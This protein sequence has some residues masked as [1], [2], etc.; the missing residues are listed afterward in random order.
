MSAAASTVSTAPSSP[1]QYPMF[2]DLH[3]ASGATTP[4]RRLSLGDLPPSPLPSGKHRIA[5]IGSGS[6][7]TALA[8]IAAENAA[9]HADMFEPTVNMWVREK[10][11]NGKKL[12]EVINKTHTNQRYLPD[13]SLPANL[14]AVPRLPDVVRNATLIVFVTPHQFLPTVISDLKR[15]G[16]IH[17]QARAVSA[18]KGVEVEGSEIK[19][20][21]SVIERDLSIP[22]SAL[23]GANIALEVALEQF[24]E[25]TIGC[26]SAAD[27][28]LWHAVFD[29]H[30]FRVTCVEDVNGVSLGGALKNV[31]A[32]AA[33]FVDGLRLGGNTKAAILRIGLKEMTE[34]CL[35]FFEGAQRNTFSNESAGVADLITT[36]YGGRNRKCAEEFV[37]SGASFDDIERRLLNGQKLQGTATAEEVHAFLKA[38]GRV[39]AYPLFERVYQ[40]AFNGMPPAQLVKGL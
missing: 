25:T 22:C 37:K 28:A 9:R 39:A 30:S 35:E 40:I 19:T 33:G 32:L 38:H 11:V 26:P 5:V 21:A 29:A 31:V 14:I 6:W 18:I 1:R 3:I 16:A 7:G 10:Q 17:P 27:S 23:S 20:F 2:D 12:T 8:K 24:C 36:C 4:E 34:F 15:A 13:V